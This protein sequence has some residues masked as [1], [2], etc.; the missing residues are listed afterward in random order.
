LCV[1]SVAGVG[2]S[3]NRHEEISNFSK[4]MMKYQ[5]EIKYLIISDGKYSMSNMINLII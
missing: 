5:Q 1:G 2:E 4:A 3:R